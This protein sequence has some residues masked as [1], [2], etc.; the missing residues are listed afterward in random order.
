MRITLGMM[1]GRIKS[2]LMQSAE[3]MLRAQ[4]VASTGKRIT[5][6]SDDIP[7]TGRVMNLNSALAEMDQFARNTEIASA[8]LGAASGALSNIVSAMQEVRKLA[9]QGANPALTDEARSGIASQLDR[10]SGELAGAGNTQHLNRYIFSGSLSNVKPFEESTSGSGLYDYNGDQSQFTVQVAPGNFASTT[11]N[12]D[13]VFNM[14]G[15][16]LAGVPDVFTAIQ[17]LK[18]RVTAGD[19]AA[20]SENMNEIDDNLNNVIAAQSQVGARQSRLTAT[21]ENQLD[22]KQMAEDLLSRTRDADMAD[23][24]IELQTK[25][26]VYQAALSTAGR[27]VQETLVDYLR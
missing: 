7:G 8:Q 5:R 15:A 20:I 23:A 1:N 18:E 25:Q 12:G 21:K 11:V 27:V 3:E 26:N 2:N 24:I 14:N 16:A 17:N 9:L 4:D 22:A 10:I 6:P 19:V 13:K